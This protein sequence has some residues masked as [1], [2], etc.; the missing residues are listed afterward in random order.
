MNGGPT[1]RELGGDD[2]ERLAARGRVEAIA[3]RTIVPLDAA[4][5][6]VVLGGYFRIFRSAAFV[7]DVTLAIAA[8]GDVL[9]ADA[10]FGERPA[11]N[12]AEALSDGL[13][14]LL[15]A[16]AWHDAAR[17]HI[18]LYLKMA[19]SLARRTAR[20]QTQLEGL[21]RSTVEGRVATTLLELA[22]DFGRPTAAGETKLD[23]PLSQED[24]ARLAATTRETCSSIVAD[25]GRR[26][27]VRG[28]RLRGMV[29]LDAAALGRAAR[30]GFEAAARDSR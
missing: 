3:R 9:A 21:S 5:L 6:V 12:G 19:A 23:L 17:E 13:I 14:L 30:D 24:L 4:T 18:D 10:A 1:P 15:S 29:V 7:R 16:E 26:G 27:I 20:V 22:S 8:R 28:S 25:F 11:E 2:L